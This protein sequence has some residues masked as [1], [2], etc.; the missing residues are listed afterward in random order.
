MTLLA[1][2][3][4]FLVERQRGLLILLLGLLHL[5]LLAGEGDRLGLVWWL[6]DV[7]LFMLWQLS[8]IHISEP[9]RPY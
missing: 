1:R 6:V 7:G 9:T 4:G 3:G 2:A 5:A 8:L